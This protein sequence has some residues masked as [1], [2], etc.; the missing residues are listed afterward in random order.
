MK[1]IEPVHIEKFKTACDTELEIFCVYHGHNKQKEPI[2][3]MY[4]TDYCLTSIE[5][6]KSD[7]IKNDIKNKIKEIQQLQDYIKYFMIQ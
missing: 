5:K 7:N 1:K 2:Y 4:I 3:T 6:I